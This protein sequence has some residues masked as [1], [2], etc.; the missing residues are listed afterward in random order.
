M[1]LRISF[2]AHKGTVRGIHFRRESYSEVKLVRCLHGA[3][4]DVIIDFRSGSPTYRCWEA[5]KLTNINGRQ[6]YIPKGFAHGFQTLCDDVEVSH[7]ISEPYAPDAAAGI[8]HN[9]TSFNI[10]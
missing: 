5:F 3:I 7:L 2:S 1:N 9:D 4:W 8:R 6:L 10:G